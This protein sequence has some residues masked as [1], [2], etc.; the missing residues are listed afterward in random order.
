MK[1]PLQFKQVLA[2]LLTIAAIATGQTARAAD[3]TLSVDNEIP[4][5][6]AG[7]WYVNMPSWNR[8]DYLTLSAADL[9]ACGYTFK[10][11]DDG[12]KNGNYSPNNNAHLAITIPDG[13]GFFVT[14]TICSKSSYDYVRF[15]AGNYDYITNHLGS[16]TDGELKSIEPVIS[17][18][19][20]VL[21]IIFNS[22]AQ[23]TQYAGLD[24][25]VTVVDVN[26][27]FAISIS[28][29]AHGTLTVDKMT[30]K[31]GETITVTP[32]PDTEFSTSEVSYTAGTWKQVINPVNN[33]Y[34]FTM[35][36]CDVSVDAVFM[37]EMM[38]IWGG[39]DVDGTVEHP[40]VISNQ[41]GWDLLSEKS[42]ADGFT[43]GL[44][45][46]LDC[47]ISTNK[48]LSY[49]NGGHLDGN[50]HTITLSN[51]SYFI[52]KAMNATFTNLTVK[53]NFSGNQ[54]FVASGNGSMTN[55]LIDCTFS[56][57][58]I[59]STLFGAGSSTTVTNCIAIFNG[60]ARYCCSG[61]VSTAYFSNFFIASYPLTL[62]DFTT[63]V[64]NGG[65]L[66]GDGS[67]TVYADSFTLNG[68]EYYA[69]GTTVTLNPPAGILVTAAHYNDGTDHAATLN[70]DG[71]ATFTMPAAN[72]TATF[73]GFAAHY[74]DADGTEQT[75][76]PVSLLCSSD[77]T[78][79][80]AGGWYAVTGEVTLSKG[81]KFSDAAHLILTDGATLNVKDHDIDRYIR[82]AVEA[83]DLNIYGQTFGTGTLNANSAHLPAQSSFDTNYAYAIK[84]NGSLIFCGGQVNAMA[85]GIKD[86]L[87]NGNVDCYGIYAEGSVNIIRGN[88]S[89]SAEKEGDPICRLYDIQAA[90]GVLLDWRRPTDR[91][92]LT[93]ATN[94]YP[95]LS[96][97]SVAQGK[98][99]WNGTEVLSGTIF[100]GGRIYSPYD[101]VNF[102]GKTL[103]P[104]IPR[105]VAG[106]GE[107]S[108]S[109][110]WAFIASPV[111][112]E[113]G[114]AP[115]T[116]GGLTATTAT[117]YD[118]Y[119]FN[120]SAN[121]EWENY[122]ANSTDFN[123]VNGQGYLYATKETKT[124][125]FMGKAFNMG[126]EDV[127]VPL[128]YDEGTEF[129]G[130][131]LVGNPF[132]V[133]AYVNRPFYKMNDGGTGI[134]P[135]DITQNPEPI[136]VGTGIM[137]QAEG[138]N[139]SVIFSKP[140]R[141][142][143]ADNHGGL[144]L[145]LLS[146]TE[147]VD[148]AILSFNEGSKLGKFY[149]GEQNANIYIP[150]GNEEYA[151]VSAGDTGEMPV[152]FKA[153][154]NGTYTLTV[155]TTLNSQLSTLNYL[156]LIDNLTGADVDL[157]P[158]LRAERS[159]PDQP[160]SYTFTA[161]TTDYESRFKLV[162]SASADA[163][164]DNEAFAFVNN[165]NI[166]ITDVETCHGASLQIVDVM[167]RIVVQGDAMNRV[168]TGGMTPGVY[169]LC[170]INGDMIRTQKIVVK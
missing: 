141:H 162:F 73:T 156:H 11:Y 161:K 101:I 2:A 42:S 20:S 100:S 44:H 38:V 48:N 55:C 35:P 36:A 69:I 97:V 25:T 15:R 46:R 164:G 142:G 91:I 78:V 65:T 117:E 89:A 19:N 76:D 96:P 133:E 150:Q 153:K 121:K 90:D 10:V 51:A 67:A 66:I 144:L 104:C 149:F 81:L 21:W 99:L 103:Q 47:D 70:P 169:V 64:R 106:Y 170:L 1:K 140:T 80:K 139:D 160:A 130:W 45:F 16:D 74:I 135:V 122:K 39:A 62:G 9:T 148:N 83:T 138:A 112:T 79:N 154:E 37:N 87:R 33:V 57:N 5:G 75:C 49:F 92:C 88:I 29:P 58:P 6:T 113:G 116:V 163:N 120:Q 4:E 3:V 115:T 131:N 114:I 54:F 107:S 145:A 13:Y 147:V 94:A 7:H 30:A 52:I 84:A 168:S 109:D 50:G 68:T 22:A 108:T 23:G 41:A 98:A 136:A 26:T 77:E 167:G 166:I 93:A 134:E 71:T 125:A 132:A 27:D 18:N 72:T 53:G 28:N 151:I 61:S 82:I 146:G 111:T 56:E 34:S 126:T 24:L 129:A 14:G 165:G 137:V 124:L 158:S 157:L 86:N 105:E 8:D 127:E 110:H 118:L 63:V 59:V 12:G 85:T 123:L 17:N 152:N 40:Y 60:T 119:R 143:S 159:N 95:D 31:L 43:N 128:V 32:T 102:N 155:S